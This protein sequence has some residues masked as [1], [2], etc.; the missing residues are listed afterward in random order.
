MAAKARTTP[1]MEQYLQAK[2]AHPDKILFF[3]MGDFYEMFHEDART[4][5]R[6]LG[7]TLTSR[8]K[9]ENPIPMA[10]IPHHA[11][12]RYL[13]ELLAAG[14]RV[15]ICDQLEDPATAKGIVKR[16]VTRVVTPGTVLEESC[17]D[18]R[19]PNFL[20]AVLPDGAT[21]AVA[22]ADV[23]T[24]EL[25]AVPCP[26][27]AVA[28]ELERL[29]P[30]ETLLPE[31]SDLL[32]ELAGRET[33]LVTERAPDR[34]DPDRAAERLAEHFGVTGLEGLGLAEHPAAAGACGALIDY[35]VETQQAAPGHLRSVRLL[36]PAEHLLLDRAT[37]RNLELTHPLREGDRAATLLSI[38]DRTRTGPG[39]RLLRS[40]L[41]RPLARLEPIR[42]R[43]EAVGELMDDAL[44]RE[45]LRE[46]LGGVADMERILARVVARRATPRDLAALGRTTALLPTLAEWGA[47]ARAERLTELAGGI[48]LLD[49]VA[50][51][52]G[53]SIVEEPPAT[54][55]EGGVIR[56]GY[57]E[58]LDELRGVAHGGRDWMA[59]FQAAEQER[60]GIPSLK[61]GFNKVFG[62]Y[63]E[64]THAHREKVPEDYVRKQTLVSAE[65]YITEE[66][67]RW[68]EKVLGAEERIVQ[69]EQD[70]FAAVRDRVGT[71]VGRIQAVARALAALD[72]LAALAEVGARRGYA[73]PE[74]DEAGETVLQESRH[75]VLEAL[76]PEGSF[77]P[78]DLRFDPDEAR[79][80]IITGPNMAGKSTYIRQVALLTL[81][82]QAGA[83]VPARRARIVLADRIFTRV[84]AA[85]DLARGRSTFMVEMNETANILRN[86]TP[87]SLVVLDE[88]GRGTSTFDGVALAWAVTEFL[89]NETGARTL[90]ATHYH[91]LAELGVI[92]PAAENRNVAVRDWGGEIVFLRKIQP[93]SCDRSYGIQVARLA[94]VP[95]AVIDR[96]RDILSGLETQ[97]AERDWSYLHDHEVLRAAAREVQGDLFAP[98]APQPSPLEEEL[99]ALDTDRLAPLDAHARL[100]DLVEKARARLGGGKA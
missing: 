4:A 32:A 13:R 52:L 49:D 12:E 96:A 80:L 26:R 39:G 66:L 54:L 9:G 79:V 31:G 99:A 90:F 22:C 78:N 84:G 43:Q 61:I 6:V 57:H 86:A 44:L 69:L 37:V 97:A 76:L 11:T 16:G 40:W 62:Y 51:L 5:A 82:A 83:P 41:L 28:D 77:V 93:G 88:V 33:G 7:L 36:A 81:M 17:L 75:P 59:R 42:R 21:A 91:E 63:I 71:E 98:Q 24:G 60:T 65:R 27:E 23:S 15:A 70:L 50:Q 56:E 100:R 38:L 95:Q 34:F 53:E 67:K 2:E 87:Q 68:E 74:V 48:D 18:A 64:V 30:A 20:T 46:L 94:G 29:G 45:E 14:Y 35:L 89:H 10:G 85:D 19:Q 55:R 92:L 47:G 3:R 72:A 58:E 1:M 8:D 25:F 73:L